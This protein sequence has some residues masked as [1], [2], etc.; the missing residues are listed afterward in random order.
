MRFERFLIMEKRRPIKKKKKDIVDKIRK[1]TAPPTQKHSGEKG[2]KGYSR[3][4]KHKNS[5]D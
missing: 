1:P 2:D 4:Q 3:K 5:P